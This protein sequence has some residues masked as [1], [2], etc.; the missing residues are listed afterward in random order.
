M[1]GN[2]MEDDRRNEIRMRIRRKIERKKSRERITSEIKKA[3]PGICV[4]AFLAATLAWDLNAPL[5]DTSK[6]KAPKFLAGNGIWY[7]P[8]DYE[9]MCLERDAYHQQEREEAELEAEM[10]QKAQE[11]SMAAPPMII[12]DHDAYLME[13]VAMAE[14][15]S[16]DTEGKALVMLVILNRVESD[17]FPDSIEGVI[18]EKE[19]FSSIDNGRY[20]SVEPDED[21]K[22]AFELITDA[23]WDRSCGATYY[24][25]TDGQWHQS[26]LKK[27]FTHGAHT[28]YIE[29]E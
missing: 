15:E 12:S 6:C 2:N 8:A 25:L 9:Q 26:H 23:H 19:A 18:F 20:D 14:A 4:G 16:E 3:M 13:K 10:I 29:K 22:K 24:D 5:P 7:T 21:C 11:R 27:L 28:F 1:H 17:R